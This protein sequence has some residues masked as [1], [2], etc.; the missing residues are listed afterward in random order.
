MGRH[1]EAEAPQQQGAERLKKTSVVKQERTKGIGCH[2]WVNWFPG[3]VLQKQKISE[4][5]NEQRPMP[6]HTGSRAA[7]EKAAG[8][9]EPGHGRD[10]RAT[11]ASH[12]RDMRH[13]EPHTATLHHKAGEHR[14]SNS[15]RGLPSRKGAGQAHAAGACLSHVAASTRFCASVTT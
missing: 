2:L 6:K 8:P 5:N 9:R 14:L 13:C 3:C 10:K 15:E 4:P 11:P 7:A 1:Q 12:L